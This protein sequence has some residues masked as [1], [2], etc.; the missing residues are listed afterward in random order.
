M[1]DYFLEIIQHIFSY[2]PIKSLLTQIGRVCRKW[3]TAIQDE[4]VSDVF[5]EI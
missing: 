5:M 3:R 4:K 2:I 1:I